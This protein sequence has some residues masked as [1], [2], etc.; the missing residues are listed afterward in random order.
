[1]KQLLIPTAL[2][3]SLIA[4]QTNAEEVTV[5]VE[6][7][8]IEEQE[9]QQI[10]KELSYR[11]DTKQNCNQTASWQD[12][13]SGADL[14]GYFFIPNVEKNKFMIGGHASQKGRSKYHC[15]LTVSEPASKPAGAPALLAA[16]KDWQRVWTDAGSG[17]TRDGSFWQAVPPDDNYRCIGSMSQLTHGQKPKLS[18]YR[19]VHKSLTQKITANALVWSDKGSGADAPVTIFKL[20]VSETYIAVA[21]RTNSAEAYDL[22]K[23]A[24]SAP[25]PKTVEAILAE[26]MAPIRADIEA[27]AKAQREQSKLAEE[28]EKK[29]AAEAAAKKKAVAE[30]KKLA[31]EAEQK[32]KEQEAAQA[33]LAEVEAV[34]EVVEEKPIVIEEKVSEE[35]VVEKEIEEPTEE[36]EV[37]KEEKQIEQELIPDFPEVSEPTTVKEEVATATTEKEGP[38]GLDKLINTFLKVLAILFGGLILLLVVFKV[39]FGKKKADT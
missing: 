7:S 20:P 29:K 2:L 3:F 1:M 4:T 34:K 35:I 25:D 30:K 6:L 16:P 17:A 24:D 12:S 37:A 26:R 39:L 31:A 11:L 21:A 14:D 23:N 9:R 10:I 8:V 32:K 33:K 27:K 5:K 36:V 19:C 15:V 38:K 18:N 28:V 13:G 22:R